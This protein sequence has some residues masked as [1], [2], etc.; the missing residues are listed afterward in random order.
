MA[1]N[2]KAAATG[3]GIIAAVIAFTTPWEGVRHTAYQ[4][5]VGVWTICMGE[6]QGVHAGMRM[7]HQQCV[8]QMARRVPDYLGPVDR[9]MPG[10]PDNRRIAYT[11][12]AW[13]LGVGALTRRTPGPDGRP[14]PG[15]SIVDLER[16]GKWKQAC[17]RLLQ[18]NK[19]GG[20]ALPGLTTRREAERTLCLKK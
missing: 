6:T 5:P 19:A 9:L 18:F 17:D 11:D 10:L 12:A 3:G 1:V 4:D 8:E 2:K 14:L 7:T 15:T 16:A 20:K 13:N